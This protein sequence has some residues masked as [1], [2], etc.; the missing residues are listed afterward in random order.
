MLYDKKN[1][2]IGVNYIFNQYIREYD[3]SKANISVLYSKGIINE[4]LYTKLYYADRMTRQVY[5]GMMIKNNK[6][7]QEVLVEGIIEA[8]QKLFEANGINDNDI[9]AIKNDA[10]FILNKIPRV[11]S[12]DGVTFVHKNTYTSFMRIGNLEVYYGADMDKEV[13]D[14]KGIKDTDLE[15]YHMDFLNIVIDYF[16]YIQK[17]G[18]EIALQYITSIIHSYLNKELPINAYRRF[19]SSNDFVLNLHTMS[20]SVTQLDNTVQN[21]NNI[22]I[23]YNF[24]IL[25][26]MHI[27]VSQLLYEEKTRK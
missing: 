10:V 20:Y 4:E 13:I 8:K 27:Y 16:R 5:I 23:S 24:D 12:F 18:P 9:I 26:T 11:L 7:I 22:D 14:I 21:K 17:S 15:L 2:S 25:K 3:I 19:R 1:Y 6:K